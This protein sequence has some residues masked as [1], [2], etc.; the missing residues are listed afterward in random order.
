MSNWIEQLQNVPV[1]IRT[2]DGQTYVPL[3][4]NAVRSKNYNYSAFNF[5]NVA[6]TRVERLQPEGYQYDLE[7]YFTGIDHLHVSDNFEASADDRRAWII[8]HPFYGTV[9]VQP[10]SIRRDNKLYNRTL[11]VIRVWETIGNQYPIRR[12][13]PIDAVNQL[14]LD[15]ENQLVANFSSNIPELSTSNEALIRST[16]DTLDNTISLELPQI[17]TSF[18]DFKTQIGMLRNQITEPLAQASSAL[19]TLLGIISFPIQQVSAVQTRIDIFTNL[20]D[21]VGAILIP[22][23]ES[24]EVENK[25]L[26]EIYGTAIMASM[27]NSAITPSDTDYRIRTEVANV[28]E[29]LNDQYVVLLNN[30][31]RIQTDRPDQQDAFTADDT[32]ARF[33]HETL[34]VTQANLFDQAFDARQERVI[35]LEQDDNVIRL[36]HRFY[37]LDEAGENETFFIDSNNLSLDEILNIKKGRIIRYYV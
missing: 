35:L 27:F 20:L 23:G 9:R 8:T 15:T 13:V 18:A 5:I 12:I 25:Q 17:G 7:L 3:W 28:A 1:E 24:V 31:E 19:R 34:A 21:Q 26:Y 30:L 33:L 22:E 32:S 16:I 6:G 2:G 36:T 4:K 14:R 11:F 10:L 37:G 29:I